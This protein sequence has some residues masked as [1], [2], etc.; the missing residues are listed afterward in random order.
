MAA[1]QASQENGTGLAGLPNW[2]RVVALV[3][4]PSTIALFLVYALTTFATN[5]LAELHRQMDAHAQV[6]LQHDAE[7]KRGSEA[8]TRVLLRICLNTSD[9]DD[10]RQRCIS[11]R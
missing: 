10:E 2:A 3:G 6:M 5:G 9:T 11:D 7:T 8:M 1:S 4:V